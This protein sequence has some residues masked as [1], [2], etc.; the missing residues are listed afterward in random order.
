MEKPKTRVAGA[1]AIVMSSIV[2][3][4]LTGFLREVL[5]PNILGANKIGDAYNM[6]FR[7]TGL[8]Y[9]MVVG[10]AIAAALIPI[11][12]GYIEKGRE[13]EGWKAAGTF[14]NIVFIVM[15]VA[16]LTG[17]VFADKIVPFMAWGFGEE[18]S[19]LTIEL[20][21]ILFPSVAFLMLA[22]ITNGILNS[23]HR[24][25]AAAY[26]PSIYNVGSALSILLLS[27]FGVETVAYG[28]M[29]SSLIYFLLQLS[30]ALKNLK[31]FRFKLYLNHPGFRKLFSLA[32]PSLISSSISQINVIIS[33]AFTTAFSEGSVVAFNMADRTW[34]MPYG[35]FAQGIGIALLPTLAAKY[36]VKEIDYYKE[37]LARGIR[38]VL[39]LALPSAVG[40][41]VLR[42]PIV[43]TIF[44]FTEQLGDKD[45]AVSA[46]AL[47]FFS[48][49]LITQS[50]VTILN[51]AFY[52][53]NDTKT[54]L[55][56]GAA[57]IFVNYGLNVF[58]LNNSPLNVSGMALSYALSSTFCAIL[59]L[60]LLDIKLNGIYLE[61]MAGFML[62][63]TPASVA[64]GLLLNVI[65]SIIP[66]GMYSKPV[67]LVY[68]FAVVVLGAL[69]YYVLTLLMRVDEAKM[70]LGFTVDKLKK[71]S[72][73]TKTLDVARTE[74]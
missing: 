59:L 11:L 64:M 12:S 40:I 15:S 54:P 3:S 56:I 62:K 4:R 6:A 60:V 16:C 25:A 72:R 55:Y 27:K 49:A 7:I 35:I 19:D 31:Y 1:A 10:G 29:F 26:G 30:F 20:S 39:F 37:T 34:Q 45:I 23:Y 42:E 22:G 48:I 65:N 13:E 17:I 2:V 14:I 73:N 71:L 24:F 61:R 57:T 9:D 69:V 53:V 44:Q 28:V 52:A 38:T 67:Q 68:L 46:S 41:I 36:A 18:A 66:T 21:R 50:M 32:I 58:F 70:I 33:A 63:A 5:V 74:K 47:M 8:M 43:R 51:R